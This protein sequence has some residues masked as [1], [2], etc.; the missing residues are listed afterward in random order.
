MRKG[1]RRIGFL[2]L[3]L[4]ICSSGTGPQQLTIS[5]QEQGQDTPVRDVAQAIKLFEHYWDS[6][7]L[8]GLPKGTSKRN[9]AQE[10]SWRFGPEKRFSTRRKDYREVYGIVKDTLSPKERRQLILYGRLADLN[11][12]GDCWMVSSISGCPCGETAGCID[13]KTGKLIFVWIM[14]EG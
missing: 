11:R 6:I 3:A 2:F 13:A 10:M 4:A 14:P 1:R 5:A 8:P 12:K 7:V 9:L